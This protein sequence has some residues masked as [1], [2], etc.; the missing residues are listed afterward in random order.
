ML[1]AADWLV[2][3]DTVSITDGSL[4]KRYRAL[5]VLFHP[6][7]NRYNNDYDVGLLRTIIDMDMKGKR[8]WLHPQAGLC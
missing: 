3:V 5:Q 7:F 8:R 2:V 6:R 4:G 1:E